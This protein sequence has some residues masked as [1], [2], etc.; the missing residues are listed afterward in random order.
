MDPRL[1]AGGGGDAARSSG[2]LPV[3]QME[4]VVVGGGGRIAGNLNEARWLPFRQ[5]VNVKMTKFPLGDGISPIFC[6]T[7]YL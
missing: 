6:G 1:S 3:L 4:E 2:A 5:L 7:I